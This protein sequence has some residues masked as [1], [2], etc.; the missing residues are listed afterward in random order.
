[1]ASEPLLFC[2]PETA[3][4][5]WLSSA[6]LLGNAGGAVLPRDSE[7]GGLGKGLGLSFGK[8]WTGDL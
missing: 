3:G 4:D 1:M 5:G 8:Q 6:G 2:C 7:V